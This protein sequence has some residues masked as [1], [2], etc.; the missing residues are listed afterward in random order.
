MS[1]NDR[2]FYD[3]DSTNYAQARY[4]C[5]WLQ[6]NGLLQK[7]YQGFV[8]N[9]KQDPEGIETL[10]ELIGTDDLGKFQTA[11]EQEVLKLRF[12]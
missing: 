3:G 7:Y 1:T 11:W 10:K 6:Q 5:Y 9:A 8:A 2:E 4:L 12:P